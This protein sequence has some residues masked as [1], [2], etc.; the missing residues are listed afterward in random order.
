LPSLD[1]QVFPDETLAGLLPEPETTS[2]NLNRSH[3]DI[4]VTKETKNHVGKEDDVEHFEPIAEIVKLTG[5]KSN[6][7]SP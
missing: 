2:L 4:L 6:I 5:D 1:L 7:S 3:V